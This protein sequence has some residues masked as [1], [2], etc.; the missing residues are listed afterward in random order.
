[1][2]STAATVKNFLGAFTDQHQTLGAGS[3][4]VVKR[5]EHRK[6]GETR[7]VKYVP[8]IDEQ[9]LV[10]WEREE[11]VLRALA[12]SSDLRSLHVVRLFGSWVGDIDS[13]RTGAFNME[14]CDRTVL[15]DIQLRAPNVPPVRT[16]LVWAA[17]LMK[18]LAFLHSLDFLHRDL[19][20]NNV[21]LQGPGDSAVLKIGDMGSS[22]KYAVLMSSEVG[23]LPYRPPEILMAADVIEAGPG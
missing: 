21:M 19:K 8:L 9:S 22:R 17:Q 7:A 20:P 18:G 13:V 23:T 12:A 16:A 6:S 11:T 1:M 14:M 2:R 10:D 3:F 4:G 5:F 15:T